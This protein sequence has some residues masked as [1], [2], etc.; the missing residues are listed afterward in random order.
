MGK[1][2]LDAHLSSTSG[3]SQVQFVSVC[4]FLFENVFFL[5]WRYCELW[6]SQF[7]VAKRISLGKIQLCKVELRLKS[8]F[9]LTSVSSENT[10]VASWVYRAEL[11]KLC[12]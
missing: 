8:P 9:A 11:W 1:V 7:Y 10:V 5:Q 4:K 3:R 2:R 12:Q 6:A